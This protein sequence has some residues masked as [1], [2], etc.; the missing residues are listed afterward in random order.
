[1]SLSNG[2]WGRFLL[3]KFAGPRPHPQLDDGDLL[4]KYAEPL[5]HTPQ[6]VPL[7]HL[8]GQ[9]TVPSVQRATWDVDPSI[10]RGWVGRKEPSPSSNIRALGAA[11]YQAGANRGGASFAR[12]GPRAK[13]VPFPDARRSRARQS[14]VGRQLPAH[15][16][17]LISRSGIVQGY[18]DTNMSS[19]DGANAANRSQVRPDSRKEGHPMPNKPSRRQ[20]EAGAPKR[21]PLLSTAGPTNRLISYIR[22]HS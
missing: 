7:T 2:R 22:P 12:H 4:T 19:A 14:A 8:E 17:A 9:G 21:L 10:Q 13:T 20:K 3:S 1:M 6:G 15:D 16:L 5:V 18:V 11:L